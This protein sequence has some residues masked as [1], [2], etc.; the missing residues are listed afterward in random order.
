[1]DHRTTVSFKR[2]SFVGRFS[3]RVVVEDVAVVK[4]PMEQN[5]QIIIEPRSSSIDRFRPTVKLEN[6]L[7]RGYWIHDVES[8]QKL[9]KVVEA[10]QR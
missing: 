8:G 3:S 2:E 9:F 1:M 5:H 7:N 10:K 4:T 6:I